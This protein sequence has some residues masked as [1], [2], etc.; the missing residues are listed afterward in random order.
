MSE[1]GGG[2]RPGMGKWE[3]EQEL[4]DGFL[5]RVPAAETAFVVYFQKLLRMEV[6]SNH[7]KL[8]RHLADLEQSALVKVCELRDDPKMLERICPP[9]SELAKFAADA[10]A[11]KEARVKRWPTLNPKNPTHDGTV[12]SNQERA[13][14]LQRDPDT[15]SSLPRGMAKTMLAHE[16]A[17]TGDGPTVAEALWGQRRTTREAGRVGLWRRW[18]GLPTARTW[19]LPQED[20]QDEVVTM[21][22]IRERSPDGGPRALRGEPLDPDER[23][24]RSSKST[25]GAVRSA[26]RRC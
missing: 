7:P 15:P 4:I 5:S 12:V 18:C 16:A 25:C 23:R 22:E 14:E 11:R 10:P 13:V 24:G 2:S 21:S 26:R 17:V 6:R 20:D 9:L 3:R 8:V 19:S 1:S